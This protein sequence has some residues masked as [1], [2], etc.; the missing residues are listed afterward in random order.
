MALMDGMQ[1]LKNLKMS[2]NAAGLKIKK[3]LSLLGCQG[4]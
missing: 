4:E 3:V 2:G 1:M